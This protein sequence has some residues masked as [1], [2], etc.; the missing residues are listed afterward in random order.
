VAPL[1]APGP[2]TVLVDCRAGAPQHGPVGS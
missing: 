1:V 2:A